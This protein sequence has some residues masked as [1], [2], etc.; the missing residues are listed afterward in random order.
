MSNKIDW[1]KPLEAYHPDG[2]VVEVELEK[3]VTGPNEDGDWEI[4]GFEIDEHFFG[5]DG[6]G[7]NW[8]IRN[9]TTKPANSPSPELVERMVAYCRI[10]AFDGSRE[11]KEIMAELE[12]VDP[13]LELARE[14]CAA[15]SRHGG[16]NY[17]GGDYDDC[18][19]MQCIMAAIKRVRA[20]GAGG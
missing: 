18:F 5:S 17:I 19:A 15:N 4:D 7:V 20:E 8:R 6:D 1:T 16:S 14:V 10:R 12:Q 2:R 9:R 11:A 3:G 13:D